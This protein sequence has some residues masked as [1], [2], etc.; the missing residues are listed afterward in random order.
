MIAINSKGNTFQDTSF[1]QGFDKNTL[2]DIGHK[3]IVDS[4]NQHFGDKYKMDYQDNVTYVG[5]IIKPRQPEI[6][7]QA[8]I[9][10]EMAFMRPKKKKRYKIIRIK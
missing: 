8:P 2:L 4:F 3:K 7:G 9:V 5:Q 1:M 6:E 10:Q